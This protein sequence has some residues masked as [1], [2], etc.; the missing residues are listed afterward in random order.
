MSKNVVVRTLV[1]A[2]AIFVLMAAVAPQVGAQSA[3]PDFQVSFNPSGG[4]S[5]GGSVNIHIKVN[6][7][8]PGA[9]RISVSCGGVSKGETSEVEFDSNWNTSGCNAGTQQITI[10]A[11]N[12]DDPN[13]SNPNTKTFGYDLTGGQP[14]PPP[15]P[16]P[17]PSQGPSLSIFAFNPGSATVGD[18]VD[19]HIVV[20]SSNPGATKLTVSCGSLD[21]NETSEVEFHSTWYTAGCNAGTQQVTVL[22]RSVDDPNWQSAT[23]TSSPYPLNAPPN[24]VQVPSASFSV[25]STNIQ[26]GQCTYLHWS[27]SG[28]DSVDIDGTNVAASG[29]KQVCPSVTTK[30]TLT[31]RNSTGPASRNL[32]VVVS[33]QPASPSVAS[34]FQT[35]NIINIGGNIYVIVSG[36]RRHVPNPD[37]LDALGIPRSWINNRGY[38]DSDLNTIPQGP[39]I[40][41]VNRDP[42]GFQSFKNWIFP[43]TAPIGQ[44]VATPYA[45]YGF[46]NGD[47]IQLGNDIF[48]MV[49]RQKRLVPNPATLDALGISRSMIN[50]KGFSPGELETIPR[51]PDIP[52]VNRDPSGFQSFKNWIFPYLSPIVPPVATPIPN[53][54]PQTGSFVFTV[55]PTSVAPGGNVTV[56]WSGYS[57]IGND[58]ISLHPAGRPD[59]EYLAWQYARGSSGSLTFTAPQKPGWYDFRMFRNGPKFATSNSFNVV[60]GPNVP[61]Q[62]PGQENVQTQD[63]DRIEGSVLAQCPAQPTDNPSLIPAAHAGD[64][65]FT[66]GE[67]TWYVFDQRPDAASWLP[68]SGANAYTW[69]QAA[70]GAGLRVDNNPAGGD[71]AVWKQECGGPY[72]TAGHVAYVTQVYVYNNETWIK[73]NEYNWN[74]DHLP[75]MGSSYKVKSCMMFIHQPTNSQ[76]NSTT[77]EKSLWEQLVDWFL[78]LFK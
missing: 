25:D 11:R 43:S 57:P 16:P 30:Y 3:G 22:S 21:K 59:S 63:V 72:A 53:Q 76:T 15:P 14:P 42:S 77:P 51:G 70:Q 7:S 60:A 34:S 19:I 37:T 61:Q 9:T 27:T 20:N 13:W 45:P 69:I 66:Y 62:P 1:T 39:D 23:T 78:N 71:I 26:A 24:P 58:W 47:I 56:Q 55:S 40:P 48:V 44:P 54:A 46:S 75:H 35:G 18:N 6:S 50:N 33:S 36:Q 52:D 31:A 8:N 28:A 17:G 2:I 32:T 65:R 10:Q 49:D 38:S 12:P 5:V 68:P 64:N 67:C 73:V 29:D 74:G 4:Q 41:D